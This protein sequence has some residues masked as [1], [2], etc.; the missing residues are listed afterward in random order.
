ME[1]ENIN[2]A[3]EILQNS[4]EFAAIIPEVKSNIVMAKENAKDIKE[5]AG[6]PGRITVIHGR[7]KV[8][9]EPEFGASSHMAR[10]VLN[11]MKHDPERR[12]ALNI[13][14]DPLLIEICERIGLVV[15][16]YDRNREPEDVK[17]VEGGTIP[18]GVEEAINKVGCVPDVVYHIGCWGKEAMICLVGPNA[19]EVAEMAVCIAKLFDNL[20]DQ[21]TCETIEDTR[22]IYMYQKGEVKDK[23]SEEKVKCVP[24]KGH[25]VIFAPSR[26]SYIGKKPNVSCIFCAIAEGNKEVNSRVLY[27]DQTNMVV[28]NMFPYNRGHIEVV[29]VKHLTDLNQLKPDEIKEIFTLVQRSIKLVREVIKPDGVNIGINLG[30]AAGSSI[31]HIHIHVV[32]RFKVE[33]GFMETTADTRVIEE[34]IDETYAKY[35]EKV[36]ILRDYHEV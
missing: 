1:I 20:K 17:K 30:E 26:S 36:D 5:V 32:P 19:V 8:F 6:V 33:A 7:P 23:K 29:P 21:N 18:W 12:S 28:M 3:V 34:S 4:P 22:L 2:R 10:L 31:E 27:K 35:M 13:R 16:S 11:I 14:Y 24:S 15:S 25:D 9:M